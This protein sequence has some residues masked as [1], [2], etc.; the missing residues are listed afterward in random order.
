MER[1]S[2]AKRIMAILSGGDEAKLSRFESKLNK[3][4]ERQ[5]QMRRDSIETLKEKIVDAKDALG[6]TITNVSVD[7]MTGTDNTE[8][9]V[10][11]YVDAVS[12]K[13]DVITRLE[14]DIKTQEE[15]IAHFEKLK[16]VI[17]PETV[18]AE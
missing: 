18:S 15:E 11:N 8:R 5:I 7:Q 9:Y 14:A 10:P 2:L 13:L 12:K 1:Q 16:A 17:Y 3:Y 4:F 6:E